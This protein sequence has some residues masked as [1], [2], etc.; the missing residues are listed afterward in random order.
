MNNAN[1]DT[2]LLGLFKKIQYWIKT[3]KSDDFLVFLGHIITSKCY[4]VT[5]QNF[6]VL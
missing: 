2:I 5:L 6:F 3:Q 4:I 1:T